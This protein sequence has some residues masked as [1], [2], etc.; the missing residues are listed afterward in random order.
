[1]LLAASAIIAAAQPMPVAQSAPGVLTAPAVQ[2]VPDPPKPLLSDGTRKMIEAAIDDGDG[3]AIDTVLKLARKTSPEA[4]DE[5]DA[6]EIPYRAEIARAKAEKE[7]RRLAQLASSDVFQNWKG[8]V[9]L[10]AS[11]TTGSRSSFGLFGSLAAERTGLRWGHKVA[12]RADIQE[13]ND[14]TTAQR[15]LAS[16]QPNFKVGERFYAFGLA[17]YEY[18]PILGYDARYTT[19]GGVG[20]GL[21]RNDVLKVEFEGGPAVRHTRDVKGPADTTLSGRGSLNLGWKI[22]P[23]LGFSQASAFYYEPGESSAT[24]QT[25]LDTKLIGSLKARLS[26]NVVYEEA[27][28]K[29]R[30]AV[31]TSSRATLI[32][33]F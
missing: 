9:E 3:K 15:V 1:M 10:G 28:P 12:A 22:G 24:A 26:Y 23:N 13:T 14:V 5:I 31:D 4:K 20:I 8:Q 17:Q 6:I 25:A 18:D 11:R 16:W 30:E 19:G 21:V 32:Y 29:G 7:Q 27:R 2:V 33:S